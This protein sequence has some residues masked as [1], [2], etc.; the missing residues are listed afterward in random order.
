MAAVRRRRKS[1]KQPPRLGRRHGII[2]GE[3]Q[4]KAS[5][6]PGVLWERPFF[7]E[8]ANA[9]VEILLINRAAAG[10]VPLTGSAA[11][12]S[13]SAGAS[14]AYWPRQPVPPGRGVPPLVQLAQSNNIHSQCLAFAALRRR[15]EHLEQ[16]MAVP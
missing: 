10:L 13:G 16:L 3:W 11:P 14:S 15:Y 6:P 2:G 4:G 8:P 5:P 12:P 9:L 7:N 1:G